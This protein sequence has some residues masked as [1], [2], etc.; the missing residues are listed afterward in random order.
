MPIGTDR[1]QPNEIIRT[2]AVIRGEVDFKM[3]CQPRF[4]YA[5]CRHTENIEEQCAIFSPAS[6]SCP[7]LALCCTVAWRQQSQDA[8][9]EC[10]L[11]AGEKVTFVFGGVRPQGQQ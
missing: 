1:E 2:L 11:R 8:V 5:M 6:D 9:S 10:S 3:R 4:N 7:P